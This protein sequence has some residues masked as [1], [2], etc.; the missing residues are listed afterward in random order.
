MITIKPIYAFSDNY[1]WALIDSISSRVIVVD[2]GDA[3]PVINMLEQH[4]LTLHAILVTHHHFDHI[5]GVNQLKHKFQ[6]IEIYAPCDP[7]IPTVT[8]TVSQDSPIGFSSFNLSFDI[9][10][11]PGHTMTHICYYEP[12]QHWLFCGDTLFCAGCGRLF[13]G[14]ASQMLNS[15]HKLVQL[16]DDT[17]VFCAHEYTKSNLEFAATIEPN[18]REIATLRQ[19]IDTIRCSLPSTI[20]TEKKINPFLRTKDNQFINSAKSSGIATSD[21][22][23][24]FAAI[25]RL[26]DRF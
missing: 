2:P 22:K 24:L 10:L 3:E 15:L 19:H 26:K 18:N 25:R 21:E 17:K 5:G 4:D 8:H 13:E 11:T 14:T 12:N 6:D 1:I 16:P 20:G 9:I 23:T 7:R